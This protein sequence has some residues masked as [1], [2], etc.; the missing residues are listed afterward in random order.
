MPVKL[1]YYKVGPFYCTVGSLRGYNGRF[2]SGIDVPCDFDGSSTFE[3]I[4]L[5][6]SDSTI[7]VP[8]SSSIV[9]VDIIP[10]N[11]RKQSNSNKGTI[12]QHGIDSVSGTSHQNV[13]GAFLNCYNSLLRR[14]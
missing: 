10:K 8:V 12:F 14:I 2:T 11:G 1:S 7:D 5:M 13:N 6:I 9:G 3:Y 4:S